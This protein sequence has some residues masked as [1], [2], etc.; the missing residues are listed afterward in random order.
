MSWQTGGG[1][2]DS[3]WLTFQAQTWSALQTFI[4]GVTV[5]GG[6][7]TLPAGTASAPSLVFSG[8]TAGW[9]A[10]A[11]NSLN[12]VPAGSSN[13]KLIAG[14]DVKLSSDSNITWTHTIDAGA[15]TNDLQLGMDLA[16]VLRQRNGTNAQTYRVY[17]TY[18]DTSN[19]SRLSISAPSGGPITL[20]SEAAGTG[21]YRNFAWNNQANGQS[22]G[23]SSVTELTTIAAAA[24]TDTAIQIP[25][26]AVVYAVSVRV[27]TV[28]PTAATFTVKGTTSSTQFDVAGGV[29]TA[30]GT[31]DVG[32]ANAPYKNGAAQ[33]IR[34]TPN[35]T[36]ADNTG[37]VRVTVWYYQITPA[38]S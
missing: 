14:W 33:T 23:L 34:I 13:V 4:A 32:T 22:F 20:A 37:R 1:W 26:N 7:L 25:A 28:I 31:T 30:A 19:Y 38:T 10:G 21:S 24:T 17:E 9:Y 18:T 16:N 27:T 8:S 5:S 2:Q 6:V 12:Y 29:S 11:G 35:L 3:L 36:P 15:G